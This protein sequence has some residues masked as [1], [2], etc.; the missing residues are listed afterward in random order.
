MTLYI[1]NLTE[2]WADEE[3]LRAGLGAHGRL[4]RA[5]IARNAQGLSKVCHFTLVLQQPECLC[6][7]MCMPL[8]V[9][10]SAHAAVLHCQED[11]GGLRVA[12][13][14][15]IYKVPASDAIMLHSW[16]RWSDD[17]LSYH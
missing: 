10:L 17:D 9:V 5:F 11:N 1:G 14:T 15:A 8:S 2:E 13:V 3:R 7:R 12:G 6:L 4:E 16:A